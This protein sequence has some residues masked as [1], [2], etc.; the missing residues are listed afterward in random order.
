MEI[1]TYRSVLRSVGQYGYG[2]FS[3]TLLEDHKDRN[4]LNVFVFRNPQF[5][6]SFKGRKGDITI[7]KLSP[8]GLKYLGIKGRLTKSESWQSYLDILLINS[9][10]HEVG[11]WSRF[12][13]KPHSVTEVKGKKVG[14]ISL[15]WG[16]NTNP[17]GLDVLLCVP[18]TKDSLLADNDPAITNIKPKLY[19]PNSVKSL[20]PTVI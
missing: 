20:R 10:M 18:Q 14:L 3:N 11:Y 4:A 19:V 15:R 2:V 7:R 16:L 9:Y 1:N 13:N 5:F 12:S 17:D 6:S 8:E